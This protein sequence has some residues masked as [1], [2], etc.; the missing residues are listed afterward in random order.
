MPQVSAGFTTGQDIPPTAAVDLVLFL[1][2]AGIEEASLVHP[3]QSCIELQRFSLP[4]N[5]PGPELAQ[6]GV[7]EA[8][9][10]RSRLKA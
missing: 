9:A 4:R 10:V 5:Q 3:G 8:G 7:V 1:A 2:S 6:H